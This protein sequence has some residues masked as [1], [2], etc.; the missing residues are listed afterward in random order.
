MD[1]AVS[2]RLQTILDMIQEFIEKELIPREAEFAVKEFSEIEPE[3]EEL[4][5]MVRQMELWAPLHPKE[6]G[7]MGLSLMEYAMVAEVLGYTPYGPVCVRMPGTGRGQHRDPAQ[8]RQ[9]RAEREVLAP[10]DRGQD[11]LLLLH[12][13]GRGVRVEPG[14]AADHGREG[15]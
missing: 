8:V 9:R 4:R 6:Y 5:N 14:L 7:G 3:I 10:V 11:P 12:D 13:R 2:E 15:R 1:F